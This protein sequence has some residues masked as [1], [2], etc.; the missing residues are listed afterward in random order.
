MKRGLRQEDEG[1]WAAA[2]RPSS[3]RP[4]SEREG[5]RANLR[6]W[7]DDLRIDGVFVVGKNVW[8]TSPPLEERKRYFE[9]AVEVAQSAPI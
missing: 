5:V 7:A 8:N 2:L 1:I 4:A 6:H 9:L 3:R